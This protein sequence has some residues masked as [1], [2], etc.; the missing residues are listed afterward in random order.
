MTLTKYKF[1]TL[2]FFLLHGTS[3]CAAWQTTFKEKMHKGERPKWMLEQ[4]R[5]DLTPFAKKKIASEDLDRIMQLHPSLLRYQIRGK[6]V[7]C[8]GEKVSENSKAVISK[9]LCRLVELT[10]LPDVDFIISDYDSFYHVPALA[11]C[12]G[13]LF[14]FAKRAKDK[15]IIL[16]PDKETL[17]GYSTV[18]NEVKRGIAAFPWSKKQA[19]AFWRGANSGFLPDR[20]EFMDVTNYLEYP[21]VKLVQLS[22]NH[23]EIVDAGF[24]SLPHTD[25]STNE[26]LHYLG[27]VKNQVSIYG[28][29]RYKYQI[30]VDGYT[31]AFQRIHWQLF[32]NCLIFKQTSP[33]R[34]WFYRALR[35]YVHYIPVAHDLNDLIE[36]I[37]WAKKHER[38]AQRLI[39]NANRFAKEHLQYEDVMLYFTLLLKEY[40]KLLRH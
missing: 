4:I 35:P 37:E 30:L 9:V 11:H 32:S 31:C 14:S 17:A 15:G 3:L 27:F 21:R 20:C 2:F 1:L 10:D 8:N 19:K 22:L 26:L 38:E 7:F 24:T 5:E 40:S 12:K 34:Q 23:P 18:L 28:H 13:P 16:M 36:K 6:E 25:P 29:L 33:D 39:K